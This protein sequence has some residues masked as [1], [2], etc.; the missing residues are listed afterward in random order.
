MITRSPPHLHPG[1]HEPV[2]LHHPLARQLET[3]IEQGPLAPGNLPGNESGLF[4]RLGD[5]APSALLEL[6]TGRLESTGP[7]RM[8]RSA[9]AT[10]RKR[11]ALPS[12]RRTAYDDTGRPV[13]YGSHVH[14]AFRYAFDFQLL[15]RG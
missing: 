14:R 9:G 11:A 1:P 8:M 7:Y 3:A 15:V 10:P 6:T 2:P 13:E 12:T 4:A 5:H